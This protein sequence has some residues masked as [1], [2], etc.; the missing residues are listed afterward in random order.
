MWLF[1]AIFSS[2]LLGIYDLFKKSSLKRNAFLPV[3]F[4]AT[5]TGAL[6]FLVLVTLSRTGVLSDTSE[7]YVPIA[8]YKAHA[9]FFTKAVIV[10][11]SWFFAYMALS[12]LPITIVVPIRSTGP[13]WTVAGAFL[14]FHERF[15]AFQWAGIIL[16][17]ISSYM[18]ALAGKKE[19][20]SFRKNKWIFAIVVATLIG[21]VSSLFDK[22]LLQHYHR[23]AIQAWFSIYMVVVLL[24]FVMILW[25]PKREQP[26]VFK[27]RWTIPAIGITLSLADFLYFYALSYPDALLG[28]VSVIR[29]SS[30]IIAFTIGAIIFKE[31][32]IKA[33]AIALTGI[34]IGVILLIFST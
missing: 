14:I 20:I 6:I 11:S 21:S 19:G 15:N 27:W 26:P 25:F 4:L 29:R 12:K 32:N 28:I 13:V 22:Y 17:I 7:I 3:L 10:G 34:L 2:I 31:Q 18:F 24:P 30:V 23:M 16:A 33:K 9:F 1:L 8:S 5:S